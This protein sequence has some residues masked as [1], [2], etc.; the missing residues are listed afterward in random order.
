M[1][2]KVKG[3]SAKPTIPYYQEIVDKAWQQ[4]RETKIPEVVTENL[5]WAITGW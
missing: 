4:L 2:R 5:E 3:F 1:Q